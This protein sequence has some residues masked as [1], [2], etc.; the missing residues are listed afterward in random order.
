MYW[1]KL[2]VRKQRLASHLWC[3]YTYTEGPRPLNNNACER[4]IGKCIH[5][6][7]SLSVHLPRSI[8]QSYKVL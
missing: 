5:T 6:S 4:H 2:H 8:H 1:S 3:I 7:S